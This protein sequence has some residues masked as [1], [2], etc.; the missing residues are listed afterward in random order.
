MA[1]WCS[2]ELEIYFFSPQE[3]GRVLQFI[4]ALQ[5]GRFHSHIADVNMETVGAEND[6]AVKYREFFIINYILF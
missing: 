2:G 3:T 1:T 6:K 5:E 4:A